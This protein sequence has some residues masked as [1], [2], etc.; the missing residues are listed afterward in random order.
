[1]YCILKHTYSH[2][3]SKLPVVLKNIRAAGLI[4]IAVTRDILKANI[5]STWVTDFLAHAQ[6]SEHPIP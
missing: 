5:T 4:M 3:V 1:M 6:G 2:Q